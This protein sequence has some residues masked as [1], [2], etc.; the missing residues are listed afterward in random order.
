MSKNNKELSINKNNTSLFVTGQHPISILEFLNANCNGQYFQSEI[1]ELSL[2]TLSEQNQFDKTIE[3]LKSRY[4][5]IFDADESLSELEYVNVS[6]QD[7][8]MLV[9]KINNKCITNGFIVID[10]EIVSVGNNPVNTRVN[11]ILV[12][13]LIK[14]L[15][16]YLNSISEKR[17]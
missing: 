9:V 7:G 13:M 14:K 11:P 1:G 3:D 6:E 15:S 17:N 16:I 12:D 2:Y 5:I 4:N 10:N 8:T